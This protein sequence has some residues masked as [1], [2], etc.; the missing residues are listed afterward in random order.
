M[1]LASSWLRLPPA[2]FAVQHG[3]HPHSEKMKLGVF[4]LALITQDLAPI[5]T[6]DH[7]PCLAHNK[8]EAQK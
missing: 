4:L 7:Y 8:S 1:E 2:V 5:F 3:A 6:A